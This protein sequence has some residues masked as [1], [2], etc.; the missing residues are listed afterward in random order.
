M[1]IDMGRMVE[2]VFRR[3][4]ATRRG[5]NVTWLAARLN[6]DRRNIYDIFRR[7][8]IDTQ[9]LAQISVALEHNFFRDI[10]E[11]IDHETNK[12]DFKSGLPFSAPFLL[13]RQEYSPTSFFIPSFY[14]FLFNKIIYQL[15]DSRQA[16]PCFSFQI[17]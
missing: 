15:L 2:D 8:T 11:I 4:Q 12:P 7:V 1:I 9:L 16:D 13:L 17:H 14:V 3:Y 6:C 10:A 5:C